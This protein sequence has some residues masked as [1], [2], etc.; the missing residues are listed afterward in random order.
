MKIEETVFEEA[1]KDLNEIKM[2]IR[3]PRG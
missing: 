1:T 2:K 3:I